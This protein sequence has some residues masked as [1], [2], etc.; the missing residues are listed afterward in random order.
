M[1]EK[2]DKLLYIHEMKYCTEM[3]TD[4]IAHSS[5]EE[6]YKHNIEWRKQRTKLAYHA[7]FRKK[8]AN[9]ESQESW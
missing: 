6:A 5:L 8:A 7:V 2:K 3:K 1:V 4:W 9:M